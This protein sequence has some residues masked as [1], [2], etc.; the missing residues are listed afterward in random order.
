MDTQQTLIGNMCAV[1][2]SR[3]YGSG[4]GEIARR[5]AEKL[6]WKL[7]DHDFVVR[8]A[9]ELGISEGDAASQDEYSQNAIGRFLS[10]LRT[11]DPALVVGP[12]DVN[13]P[14]LGEEDYHQNSSD[15]HLYDLVINTD[16]L[17]LDTA[18]AL[19][20]LALERKAALLNL[21]EQEIG[22]HV[23]FAHYPGQVRDLNLPL[24]QR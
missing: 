21:P 1:T 11:M 12:P 20:K 7:V 22:A 3:E 10:S 18:V 19:I 4:G 16:A 23:G 5:L 8:V 6:Q 15:A 24:N 14:I 2:V 13:V 9:R 17:D